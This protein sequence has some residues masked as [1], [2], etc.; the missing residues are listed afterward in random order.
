MNYIITVELTL[1]DKS[2]DEAVA[3]VIE[4]MEIYRNMKFIEEWGI[5]N[6]AS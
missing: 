2:E 3:D 6:V 1:P 4:L 5:V